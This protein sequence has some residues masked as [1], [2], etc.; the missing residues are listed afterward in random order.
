VVA[1]LEARP[2][3]IAEHFADS[4]GFP[5]PLGRVEQQRPGWRQR[6]RQRGRDEDAWSERHRPLGHRPVDPQHRRARQKADVLGARADRRAGTQHDRG[7]VLDRA[8]HRRVDPS[9]QIRRNRPGGARLAQQALV[10]DVAH[11]QI[12]RNLGDQPV[13]SGDMHR[14][15]VQKG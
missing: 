13:E 1:L 7:I 3:R 8:A 14:R 11:Q 12:R 10:D 15:G 4:H 6:A 2:G 9:L 5:G